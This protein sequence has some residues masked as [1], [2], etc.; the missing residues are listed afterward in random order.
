MSTI[1]KR[2]KQVSVITSATATLV[3]ASVAFAPAPTQNPYIGLNE[4]GCI[5]SDFTQH[6]MVGDL[7][8]PSVMGLPVERFSVN[9]YQAAAEGTGC[10]GKSI[11]GIMVHYGLDSENNF[12]TAYSFMCLN[13]AGGEDNFDYAIS[14]DQIYENE[15][16][17]LVESGMSLTQWQNL[18]QSKWHLNVKVQRT[19]EPGHVP[20]IVGND[21]HSIVFRTSGIDKMISDNSMSESDMIEVVPYTTPSFRE[22]PVETGFQPAVCFVGVKNGERLLD[23][24][25]YGPATYR[26]KAANG[27]IKCP[28]ACARAQFER[29]TVPPRQG[30]E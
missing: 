9:S 30:C 4:F 14:L 1:Y 23:D 22:G 28:P 13:P 24:E 7:A 10:E 26:A 25:L 15:G 11:G 12:K 2:F 29:S 5:T 21:A 8:E 3:I 16:G 17:E 6:F 20:F 18:F 19:N 27:G